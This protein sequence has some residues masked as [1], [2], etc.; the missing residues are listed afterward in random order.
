MNG[1]IHRGLVLITRVCFVRQKFNQNV[2]IMQYMFCYAHTITQMLNCF[3]NPSAQCTCTNGKNYN[4]YAFTNLLK[5]VFFPH[6]DSPWSCSDCFGLVRFNHQADVHCPIKPWRSINKVKLRREIG[7]L[8][9]YGATC[10]SAAIDCATQMFSSVGEFSIS[11]TLSCQISHSWSSS[12][13]LMISICAGDVVH[14]PLACGFLR[15]LQML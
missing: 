7:A 12:H 4:T 5:L 13:K 11:L 15:I 6:W 14:E 10:L 9:P 1:D 2:N 8:R 3:Q